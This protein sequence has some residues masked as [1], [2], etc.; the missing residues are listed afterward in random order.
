MKSGDEASLQFDF[1][2]ASLHDRV[3]LLSGGS[4]GLGAACASLLA[5][6]GARLV[7][8]YHRNQSR[9]DRLTRHLWE[10]YQAEAVAV[11][12]DIASQSGREK[13]LDAVAKLGSPLYAMVCLVGDPARVKLAD[14][15]AVDLAA[16]FERN[17]TG[18]ILLARDAV[19]SFQKHSVAGSIVLFSTMQAM[20]LFPGSIN[21]AGPKNALIHAARVLAK[22]NAGPSGIRVNVVSPGVNRAGMALASIQSGKYDRYV[23]EGII[24]R[25]GRAEDVARAVRLFLEPDNYITGQV[26][27]VDGGFSLQI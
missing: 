11:G 26:L 15:E 13:L 21:Y 12:S 27:A 6:Q 8:G 4:G 10:T 16:S 9:A 19:R 1:P 7:I 23:E 18:P 14:A 22:E 25:F 5:R 17:Y 24:P 3:I 20:A 2:Q